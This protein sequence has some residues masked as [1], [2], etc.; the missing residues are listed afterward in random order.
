MQSP[1]PGLGFLVW[2]AAGCI[3]SEDGALGSQWD[4]QT[5]ANSCSHRKRAVTRQ[6]ESLNPLNFSALTSARS[7]EAAATRAVTCAVMAMPLRHASEHSLV[8]QSSGMQLR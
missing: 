8:W 7:R 2:P 4:A 3:L 1:P 5:V 6:S